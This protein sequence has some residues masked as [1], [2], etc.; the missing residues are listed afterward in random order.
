MLQNG[1]KFLGHHPTGFCSYLGRKLTNYKGLGKGYVFCPLAQNFLLV[2]PYFQRINFGPLWPL[3]L[4]LIVWGCGV[5]NTPFT[6]YSRLS[7]RLYNRF[8]NRLYRINIHPSGCQTGCQTCTT[9]T[10]FDN[11]FDNPLTTGCIHDTAGCQA[12]LT[13]GCI[14]Y[15]N[16]QPVV[17]PV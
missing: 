8:D 11:R 14:V 5:C 4:A 7:S 10:R 6:R 9:G 15:T 12:G 3:P 1:T 16:I 13:T 17:K 2:G